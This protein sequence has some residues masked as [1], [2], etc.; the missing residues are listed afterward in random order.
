MSV[1]KMTPPSGPVL[2]YKLIR[3]KPATPEE[4]QAVREGVNDDLLL[5]LPTSSISGALN[6]EKTKDTNL[7]DPA[8]T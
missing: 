3:K 4:E 8:A 6:N 7:S 1:I 2:T 5:I